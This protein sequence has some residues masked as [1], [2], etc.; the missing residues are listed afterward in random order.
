MPRQLEKYTTNEKGEPV[1]YLPHHAVICWERSTTKIRI[2]YDGSAK[3]ND[4]ELSVNECLQTG[5]NVIPKLFAVLV[6][7]RSHPVAIIS[8]IKK[9]FLMIDIVSADRDV[10]R[11][12][13]FQDPS[14]LDSPIIQFV[15]LESYLALD[16]HLND[17]EGI[18]YSLS[19]S[20]LIYGRKV[21]NIPNVG[22]LE[23]ISTCE[24]LSRQTRHHQILL[25]H[26]TNQWR[27]Q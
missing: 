27:R 16:P 19:P 7:F 2:V 8:D 3:L 23:T 6:Q 24:S 15:S 13:W 12:L 14:K 18:N 11:F 10:L 22:H 26:F 17:S 4:S 20:H 1:H 5:P 9:A 21:A 25:R